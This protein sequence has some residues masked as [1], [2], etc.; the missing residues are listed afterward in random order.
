M[1][2]KST[3]FSFCLILVTACANDNSRFTYHPTDNSLLNRDDISA[4]IYTDNNNN[5]DRMNKAGR[6]FTKRIEDSILLTHLGEMDDNADQIFAEISQ[7]ILKERNIIIFDRNNL[8]LSIFD[9][10][11]D[12][13]KNI[14]QYG[15]GPGDLTQA[16]GITMNNDI[17]YISDRINSVKSVNVVNDN[18]T[19]EYFLT[20]INGNPEG[21]CNLDNTIIFK[22]IMNNDELSESKI[23]HQYDIT[24]K[25]KVNSFGEPYNAKNWAAKEMLSSGKFSCIPN[26][27]TLI[28]AFYIMPYIYSYDEMGNLSWVVEID[29]YQPLQHRE[30]ANSMTFRWDESAFEY[31]EYATLLSFNNN[32]IV[33]TRR[34]KSSFSNGELINDELNLN[35]YLVDSENGEGTYL[36]HNI[37]KILYI[38][39][40]HIVLDNEEVFPGILV[41]K[42]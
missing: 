12:H 23:F 13:I 25:Q 20:D 27:N 38:D 14:G 31:D 22:S 16:S 28:N 4:I 21:I 41:Y 5:S 35:T 40:E 1:T 30:D 17:V 11:G 6:E 36:G 19:I 18:D 32:I 10:N 37:P 3:I 15:R 26:K 42:L 2:K 9:L 33:Q 39:K 24:T 8:K 7:V 34:Y 29:E